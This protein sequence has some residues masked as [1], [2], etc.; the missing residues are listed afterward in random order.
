[1]ANDKKLAANLSL[2]GGRPCLDFVNTLDWR[3]TD[4]PVESLHNYQ[5]LVAW[6][7]HA[8]MISAKEANNLNQRSKKRPSKQTKVLSMPLNY[9]RPFIVSFH[10]SLKASRRPTKTW[11]HLINTF[12]KS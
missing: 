2:L 9:E 6:T 1:M 5:D 11:L 4:K 12:H 3:G 8:G 10:P 7:R